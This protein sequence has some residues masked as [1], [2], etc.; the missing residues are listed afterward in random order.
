MRLSGVFYSKMKTYLLI[1]RHKKLAVL[2]ILVFDLLYF[3]NLNPDHLAL[4]VLLVGFILV[5]ANIYISCRIIY[6]L[7][8]LLGLLNNH[9]KWMLESVSLFIFALV[10]MQALG[11][12]SFMDVAALIPI[13]LLSYG[14]FTYVSDQKITD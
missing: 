10:I 8:T 12:L 14:Y 1:R 13:T 5:L 2:A 4:Y 9:R 6:K 3:V 7:M 11:Q